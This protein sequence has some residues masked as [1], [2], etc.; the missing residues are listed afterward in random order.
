MELDI[1]MILTSG[2]IGIIGFFI[3]LISAGRL[4][5][6]LSGSIRFLVG[7]FLI[8]L[9]AIFG[10]NLIENRSSFE[11]VFNFLCLKKVGNWFFRFSAA[12]SYIIILWG[13]AVL[14]SVSLK[15]FKQKSLFEKKII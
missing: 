6:N 8:L 1:D 3:I 15:K 4:Q 10:N 2:G 7:G 13:C 9:F 5:I 11:Y 12:S 14:L